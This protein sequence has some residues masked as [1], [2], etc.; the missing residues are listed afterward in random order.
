M[1]KNAA[2]SKPTAAEPLAK[3]P[4][5]NTNKHV[6]LTGFRHFYCGRCGR[7]FDDCDDG[8]TGYGRPEKYAERN[9]WQ[10]QQRKA[11]RQ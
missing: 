6:R 3:C 7:E 1:Q 10:Q 4:W 2:T 5:C 8:E 11:G 9:E